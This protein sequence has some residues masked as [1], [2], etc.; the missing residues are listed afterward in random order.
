MGTMDP[1]L[2]FIH[3]SYAHE[4]RL[5]EDNQR[6]EFLGDAVLGL[7]AAEM[8]YEAFPLAREGI[9][10]KM[11]AHLVR[12][13]ALAA[14]ARRLEIGRKLLLGEG[15]RRRGGAERDSNLADAFEAWLGWMWLEEGPRAAR[16]RVREWFSPD[17]EALRTDPDVVEDPKSLLQVR[18]QE[19][20]LGLPEYRSVGAEGPD[21]AVQFRVRVLIGGRPAGEG[22]GPSKK[23]AE[24]AAAREALE[25]LPPGR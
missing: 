4:Q 24:Q 18:C 1:R 13:E 21:H 6:L 17:L 25:A 23:A 10:T 3:P 14:A 11:K 8:V 16:S 7:L 15:E 20:G 2:P 19:E 22:V 9:L 12:K 5:A